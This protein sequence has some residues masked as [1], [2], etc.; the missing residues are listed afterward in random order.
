MRTMLIVPLPPYLIVVHGWL[1]IQ[2][3]LKILLIASDFRPL[4]MTF[5]LHQ[6]VGDVIIM[7]AALSVTI[8][9]SY[10]LVTS[11]VT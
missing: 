2:L 5:S 7:P 1:F 11:S 8:V 4:V 6:A 3:K 9:T 10:G